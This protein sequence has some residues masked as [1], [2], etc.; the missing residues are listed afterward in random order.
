MQIHTCIC[1]SKFEIPF[2]L[3]ETGSLYVTLISLE[4]VV[5]AQEGL[6][7]GARLYSCPCLLS[8]GVTGVCLL[9]VLLGW[10][11]GLYVVLGSLST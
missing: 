10:N 1:N 8:T 3:C 7:H 6:T 5:V 9:Y 4:H 2:L 11:L